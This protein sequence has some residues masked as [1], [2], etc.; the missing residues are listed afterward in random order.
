MG[1]GGSSSQDV[2]SGDTLHSQHVA[3][4]RQT[5][6]RRS[7][8]SRASG[9]CRR[10]QASPEAPAGAP[11]ARRQQ[12]LDDEA[13]ARQL[14]SEELASVGAPSL[15]FSHHCG[16]RGSGFSSSSRPQGLQQGQEL[17]MCASCPFCSAQNQFT[18]QT[19]SQPLTI[20]CG[21][22]TREFQAAVPAQSPVQADL[23]RGTS[24]QLCRR[25]GTMNQIPA[26]APGQPQPDVAC[27]YCGHITSADLMMR[28]QR[29]DRDIQPLLDAMLLDGRLAGGPLVRIPIGGQRR[30]IPLA[31]LI[32]LMAQE[33]DKSNPASSSDVAAL[34]SR[35]L[36]SLDNL[37]DQMKCLVCLEE[38]TDGDDVK[39]MPCLHIYHQSALR[40]G[41]GQTTPAPSASTRSGS[42]R[43]RPV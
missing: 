28:R 27:G 2:P 16:S 9:G 33:S 38:F 42:D 19:G 6:S 23:L 24:L 34:P 7:E 10:P 12:E 31:L 4:S 8:A 37:G 22:C 15:R 43:A 3:S 21:S 41:L 11:D 20:R 40:G 13:F 25:C 5:H 30:V 14:M 39:T 35:K 29:R 17:T 18:A 36:A 26:L 32:A 1:A